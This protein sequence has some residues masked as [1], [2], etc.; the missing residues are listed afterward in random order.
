MGKNE[1]IFPGIGFIYQVTSG[2]WRTYRNGF[3]IGPFRTRE[4]AIESL[5]GVPL[6]VLK[7]RE[8]NAAKQ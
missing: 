2:M 4:E 7:N 6:K 8:N 3:G 5:N 1:Q